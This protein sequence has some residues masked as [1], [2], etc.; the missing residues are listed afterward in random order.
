[1]WY[2]TTRRRPFRGLYLVR[3]LW[4]VQYEVMLLVQMILPMGKK[5]FSSESIRAETNEKKVDIYRG[6]TP[7]PETKETQKHPF[8]MTISHHSMRSRP[9]AEPQ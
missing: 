8:Q 7:G 2:D 9:D 5:I 4:I 1:M 3:L 6:E